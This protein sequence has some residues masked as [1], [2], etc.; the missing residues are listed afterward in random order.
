MATQKSTQATVCGLTPIG[1][2]KSPKTNQIQ[3]KQNVCIIIIY[4]KC[5]IFQYVS[6]LFCLQTP[7][8]PVSVCFI[9][10]LTARHSHVIKDEP[11]VFFPH[12]IYRKNTLDTYKLYMNCSKR[13]IVKTLRTKKK[14][15][16]K[17]NPKERKMQTEEELEQ[18]T[19]V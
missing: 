7:P 16:K 2:K 12:F 1:K 4:L 15:K 14:P 3:L 18:I 17:P 6:C 8:P 9:L 10:H 19:N 13:V 11:V 5:M